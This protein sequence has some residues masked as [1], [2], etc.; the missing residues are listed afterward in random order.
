MRCLHSRAINFCVIIVYNFDINLA[1]Y[2]CLKTF[3]LKALNDIILLPIDAWSATFIS[4]YPSPHAVSVLHIWVVDWV[5]HGA[6]IGLNILTKY[7]LQR[8]FRPCRCLSL[9]CW[10]RWLTHWGRAKMV[11]ISQ[12]TFPSALYEWKYNNFVVY[13]TELCSKGLNKNIP[14]V[15][16]IWLGG[17]EATSHHLSDNK[18]TDAHIRHLASMIHVSG[19]ALLYILINIL[20]LYMFYCFSNG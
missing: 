11:D 20:G 2:S 16:Q 12:M 1:L 10:W 6:S 3:F 14:A 17:D 18:L 4:I 13:F 8:G 9:M 7:I 19:S 5:L 15:A